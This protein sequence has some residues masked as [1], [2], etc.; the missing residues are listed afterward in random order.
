MQNTLITMTKIL[1]L[2]KSTKNN[3][4]SRWKSLL[5]DGHLSEVEQELQIELQDIHEQLMSEMLTEVGTSKEFK[6]KLEDTYKESGVKDLRQRTNRIQLLTGG[7]V[8]YKSFYARQIGKSSDLSTRHL[9]ELYWGCVKGSSIAY[10]S[11]VSAYSVMCPSLEIGAKLLNLHQTRANASRIRDLSLE[12]GA[13]SAELGV[14]GLLGSGETLVGKRVVISLDGGRSR[15]REPNGQV[16]K[17]GAAC[18]NT[19]WREPLIFVIQVLN[20]KGEL[21]RKLSLPFYYGT[22]KGV[23]VMMKKLKEVLL[24]LNAKEAEIIQ[25]IADGARSFWARIKKV[26]RGIGINFS[27]VVLT[28]DYFHAVEH[29]KALS[30]FLPTQKEEEDA[31]QKQKD[32]FELWKGWLWEGLANSIANDFKKRI[33]AAGI[34]LTLEM[35]T[36]MRYFTKHHDHMQYKQMKRRKLLCGS[37]LVESAVRRI[38]NLRFKGPSTFWKEDNLENLIIL[39]CAFLAGRWANLLNNIK[40]RLIKG[41]TI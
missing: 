7:W 37:G 31:A 16:N 10:A 13:K 20:E 8:I 12:V 6:K 33:K 28:L 29:L 25:F 18:Y 14:E 35:K 21:E 27:K 4:Y 1:N 38:I 24:L 5:A 36:A 32:V 41:G 11:L 23:G 39:R 40:L 3:L 2:I 17:N 15:M 19:P 22:L 34:D 30:L 9:S 26:F